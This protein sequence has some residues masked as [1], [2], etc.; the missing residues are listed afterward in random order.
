MTIP[1]NISA[2]GYE[3]GSGFS[4]IEDAEVW[5]GITVPD[6]WA[7][8]ESMLYSVGWSS[9]NLDPYA[10]CFSKEVIAADEITIHPNKKGNKFLVDI[11]NGCTSEWI[12][13]DGAHNLMAFK[14]AIAP[15]TQMISFQALLADIANTLDRG[16]RH[17]HEHAPET[18]CRMCESWQEKARTREIKEKRETKPL[19]AKTF[20]ARLLAI[21]DD[22]PPSGGKPLPF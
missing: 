6:E 9:G 13:I 15:M 20:E 4:T 2:L 18:S 7:T 3:Q 12:L 8:T 17:D 11:N 5:L 22:A 16:F 1:K 14:I 21:G 19:D 10:P